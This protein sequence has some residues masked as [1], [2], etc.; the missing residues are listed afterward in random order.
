[1]KSAEETKALH[2]RVS[3]ANKHWG[4]FFS[5]MHTRTIN[6]P[7]LMHSTGV[8]EISIKNVAANDCNLFSDAEISE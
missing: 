5:D 7:I 6:L 3:L 4:L 2:R 1:M 8:V